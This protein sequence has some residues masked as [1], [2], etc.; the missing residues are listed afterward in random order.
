[1]RSVILDVGNTSSKAGFFDEAGQLVRVRR[2]DTVAEL[3]GE[4][5]NFAP[6]WALVASVGAAAAEIGVAAGLP[7]ARTL[8][9][10]AATPLPITLVYTTPQTLGADRVAAAVGARARFP[11]EA[12][13]IIDAGTCLKCDVVTAEGAF[14]GGSISPGL[15][16]RYRALA[17]FTHRLPLVP[18]GAAADL[19]DWP[20]DS[21]AASIRAGVETGFLSEAMAF[22]GWAEAQWPGARV[23]LTGGD[24]AWL[25]ARLGAGGV[26][27]NFAIEP[28]L[29]LLGLHQIL[30]FSTDPSAA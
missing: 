29:V 28:Q 27:R 30:L 16:L 15:R 8:L 6:E 2:A 23:A 12:V 20:G 11:G 7:P 5:S 19:P 21:T 24:S 13:L 1:M 18:P 17:E 3:Q 4:I 22:V 14:V 10:T 9:F 25:A 26:A